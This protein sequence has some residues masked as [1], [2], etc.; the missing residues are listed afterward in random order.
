MVALVLSYELMM[1]AEHRY[2]VKRGGGIR[3]HHPLPSSSNA[4]PCSWDTL[5]CI[6]WSEP[7]SKTLERLVWSVYDGVLSPGPRL[8]LT[9]PET[10][11]QVTRRLAAKAFW[12][13]QVRCPVRTSAQFDE[14]S[15][16]RK[17]RSVVFTQPLSE[18]A[19]KADIV[20]TAIPKREGTEEGAVGGDT[21]VDADPDRH[22]MAWM[23][24]HQTCYND[25]R[26]K[27]WPLLHPLTDGGGTAMHHLTHHLLL[28]WEWSSATHPTS[29]PPAPTNK[30]IR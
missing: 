28:T 30:E 10:Y 13:L 25:E 23:H 26:I 11:N 21:E 14:L 7:D 9:G 8:K 20:E 5:E 4:L 15:P 1:E 6:A 19:R 22:P 3:H 29:C 12:D 24:N 17:I 27:F 2:R 16:V 18:T